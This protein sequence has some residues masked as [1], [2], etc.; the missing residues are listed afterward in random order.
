[1]LIVG[2]NCQTQIGRCPAAVPILY[3][4]LHSGVKTSCSTENCLQESFFHVPPCRLSEPCSQLLLPLHLWTCDQLSARKKGTHIWHLGTG[5]S[6]HGL[7]R[8]T[9]EFLSILLLSPEIVAFLAWRSC[10]RPCRPFSFCFTSGLCLHECLDMVYQQLK[11]LNQGDYLT[12]ARVPPTLF[13][14]PN[15]SIGHRL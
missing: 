14:D 7:S 6:Q 15:S 10:K 3:I 4:S 1:M 9:Q 8:T 11:P 12:L 2:A 13:P 5:A